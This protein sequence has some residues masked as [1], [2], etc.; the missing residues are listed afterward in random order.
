MNQNSEIKRLPFKRSFAHVEG[1]WPSHIYL[2]IPTTK[3]LLILREACVMAYKEDKVDD[4]C[5]FFHNK[6]LHLSLSK[7]FVLLHHQIDPFL[8]KLARNIRV[9][10]D[11][12]CTYYSFSS[13]I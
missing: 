3:K 4:G 1:N 6:D 13:F 2:P 12:F 9:S 8:K 10:V 11:F 5:E 7:P